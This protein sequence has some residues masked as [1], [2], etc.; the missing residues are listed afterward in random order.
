MSDQE[1]VKF[2]FTNPLSFRVSNVLRFVLRY[3][4]FLQAEK[5]NPGMFKEN[6][7]FIGKVCLQCYLG[8][9]VKAFD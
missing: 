8:I 3:F 1:N 9:A 4:F 7:L 2:S 6:L 5:M